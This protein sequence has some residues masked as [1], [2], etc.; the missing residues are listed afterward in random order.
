MPLA[1]HFIRAY[2]PPM[3]A[4]KLRALRS[5]LGLS[6]SEFAE[7]LGVNQSTIARWEREERRIGGPASKLL[8]QLAQA[9]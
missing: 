6:Q 3:T 4:K 5:K 9:A 8:A 2:R 1:F 7:L